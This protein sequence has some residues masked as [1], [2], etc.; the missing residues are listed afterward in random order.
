MQETV[1]PWGANPKVSLHENHGVY[2]RCWQG[3][4]SRNSQLATR[5]QQISQSMKS[6]RVEEDRWF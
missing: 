3:A 5:Q 1:G 2:L 6:R 4:G